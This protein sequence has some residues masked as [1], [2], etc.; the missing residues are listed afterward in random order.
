M[1]LLRELRG[2]A[3]AAVKISSVDGF[4]GREKEAVIISMVRCNAEGAI[5]FLADRR[6]CAPAGGCGRPWAQ[7]G[8]DA[9]LWRHKA[10]SA[11]CPTVIG[12][13]PMPRFARPG[14]SQALI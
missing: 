2:G 13:R 5:G 12:A 11:D 8:H 4:Q 9:G 14:R 10:P 3:L 1:A 6:R 7:S